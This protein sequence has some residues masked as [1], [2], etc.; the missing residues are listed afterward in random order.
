MGSVTSSRELLAPIADVWAFV[1]T[2]GRLADWWPGIFA[3]QDDGDHWTIEGEE[4][5]GLE[6]VADRNSGLPQRQETVTIEKQPPTR[7]RMHF[8]RSGYDVS[9]DLA[10]TSESR[11]TAT[12]TIG[13]VDPAETTAERLEK[14]VGIAFGTPHEEFAEGLLERLYEVCQSGAEA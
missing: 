3:A 14:L 11:T 2:P 1:S 9:L 6:R 4:R 13:V 7:L 12:L 5:S 8:E 10:S